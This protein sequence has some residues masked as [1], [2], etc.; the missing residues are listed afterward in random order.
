MLQI[1]NLDK[2]DEEIKSP[3]NKE[4]GVNKVKLPQ[5]SNSQSTVNVHNM[6]AEVINTEDENEV[7]KDLFKSAKV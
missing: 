4:S 3:L 5:L 6:S 7:K 1:L 2:E